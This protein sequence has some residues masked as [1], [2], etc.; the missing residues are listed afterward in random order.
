MCLPL[1]IMKFQLFIATYI[2]PF[3]QIYSRVV[4]N[5]KKTFHKW[6]H[7]EIYHVCT[8]KWLG[9][10]CKINLSSFSPLGSKQKKNILIYIKNEVMIPLLS[11]LFVT[12]VQLGRDMWAAYLVLFYPR[13]LA[14]FT[15]HAKPAH[16]TY[17]L[18]N[19]PKLAEFAQQVTL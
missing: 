2:Q 1:L 3:I 15:N 17:A 19:K 14:E 5:K 4:N 6:I 10:H 16:I 11:T 9:K 12:N 13:I 18:L 8:H 7:N